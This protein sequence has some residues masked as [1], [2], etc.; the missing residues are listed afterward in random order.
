M[1]QLE[2]SHLED[3]VCWCLDFG[4]PSLSLELWG[5]NFCC[6]YATWSMVSVTTAWRDGH[7]EKTSTRIRVTRGGMGWWVAQSLWWAMAEPQAP[8]LVPT[9]KKR[10]DCSLER[11][12][13]KESKWVFQSQQK[14]GARYRA[15]RRWKGRW[16]AEC[17]TL[18]L[19]HL[20][21]PAS[22]ITSSLVPSLPP[23][24]ET[25]RFFS[26]EKEGPQGH[27]FQTLGT[28]TQGS[29]QKHEL[30]CLQKDEA[31]KRLSLLLLETE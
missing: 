4:L 24:Q 31:R 28:S 9:P 11:L 19:A 16:K 6:L 8:S 29:G 18:A 14:A 17:G 3:W 20:L 27:E 25:A 21:P 5:I 26:G 15:G 10:T 7:L 22:R 13:W 30:R 12:V 23:G 1:N 2:E